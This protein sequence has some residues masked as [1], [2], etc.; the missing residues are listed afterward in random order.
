MRMSVSDSH[1]ERRL[2]RC[3]LGYSASAWSMLSR[4]SVSF[5]GTPVTDTSLHTVLHLVPAF[6]QYPSQ[7]GVS[8]GVVSHGRL[9]WH[10]ACGDQARTAGTVVNTCCRVV[11]AGDPRR[12]DR[13]HAV[14]CELL[15]QQS[16]KLGLIEYDAD[17]L[18]IDPSLLTVIAARLEPDLRAIEP[19]TP[20]TLITCFPF[21]YLG[22]APDRFIVHARET[23]HTALA[24]GRVH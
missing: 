6:G 3:R 23:G 12:N 2:C 18:T 9:L 15:P 8:R 21:A 17:G 22:S 14:S 11:S 13:D 20:L 1:L 10:A 4:T 19:Q 5:S 16:R 7:F 24:S